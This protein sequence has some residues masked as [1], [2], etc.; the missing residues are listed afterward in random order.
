MQSR[1][2][3]SDADC[4]ELP[5]AG[6]GSLLLLKSSLGVSAFLVD[7][8]PYTWHASCGAAG[9]VVSGAAVA[10]M[11]AVVDRAGEICIP[12]CRHELWCDVRD[13]AT[14]GPIQKI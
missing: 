9:G 11:I 14:L 12:K 3:T 13:A 6:V 5:G 7:F 4:F 1:C 2:L 8:L 10:A